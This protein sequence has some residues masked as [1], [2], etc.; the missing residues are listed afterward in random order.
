[1]TINQ[2]INRP[3]IKK[4]RRKGSFLGGNPQK[5]GV[6]LNRFTEQPKKPN[7]ASRKLALIK[8]KVRPKKKTKPYKYYKKLGLSNR[9]SRI[10]RVY[11]SG[12]NNQTQQF[13]NVLIQG[14]RRKD[15]IS[16]HASVINGALEV[17]GT[18]DRKRSRSKYGVKKYST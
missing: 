7:S 6:C 8:I 3:R 15:L 12:N 2:L 9:I 14:E 5:K 16:L 17:P 4:K 1:M 13:M 18:P 11:L 10:I